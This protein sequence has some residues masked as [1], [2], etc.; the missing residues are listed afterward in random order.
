M[1]KSKDCCP[2]KPA[3]KQKGNMKTHLDGGVSNPRITRNARG[4]R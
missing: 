2:N 3:K 4:K 1:G